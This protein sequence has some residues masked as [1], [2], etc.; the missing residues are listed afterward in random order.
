MMF[1]LETT[2]RVAAPYLS[3]G[4]IL[5]YDGARSDDGPV[6]DRH[7]FKYRGMGADEDMA[8]D[9]DRSFAYI[10]IV[11]GDH[12]P[13]PVIEIVEIGIVDDTIHPDTGVIADGD[14][15]MTYDGRATEAYMIADGQFPVFADD[16]KAGLLSSDHIVMPAVLQFETAPG[17]KLSMHAHL[18]FGHAVAKTAVSQTD[19]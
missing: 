11:L 3:R 9:A 19:P 8:S 17:S 4:D 2:R 18:Q 7:S 6:S 10:G 1:C 12:R 13:F 5:R 14:A 16:K 15:L